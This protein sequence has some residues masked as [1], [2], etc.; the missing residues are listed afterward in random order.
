[1]KKDSN[2]KEIVIT[3]STNKT[4]TN[5]KKKIFYNCIIKSCQ[6]F[7]KFS[8]NDFIIPDKTISIKEIID[9]PDDPKRL[10]S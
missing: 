9:P 2:C 3:I 6:N 8:R 4:F 1:M 5:S 10:H 7:N